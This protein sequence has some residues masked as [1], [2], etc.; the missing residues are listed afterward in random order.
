MSKEDSSEGTAGGDMILCPTS[1]DKDTWASMTPSAQK[2]A[3]ERMER[4]RSKDSLYSTSTE[5][6]S[7]GASPPV[8][9]PNDIDEATWEKMTAGAQKAAHSRMSR[10]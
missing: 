6:S 5:A 3:Q 2:A 4:K 10:I 1:I 9:R 7:E 8:P